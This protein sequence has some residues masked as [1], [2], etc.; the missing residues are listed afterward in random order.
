MLVRSKATVGNANGIMNSNSKVFL[1][2]RGDGPSV[3]ASK[4]HI[5]QN[6]Q[7]YEN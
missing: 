5:N 1:G 7:R 6:V 2:A 3:S 4:P